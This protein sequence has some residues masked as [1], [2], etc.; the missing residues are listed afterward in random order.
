MTNRRW[1]ALATLLAPVIALAQRM[2]NEQPVRGGD[3]H[4]GRWI[5]AVV[6]I[7]AVAAVL[8]GVRAMRRRG[9]TPGGP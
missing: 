5:L 2:A 7:A 3:M 9:P 8:F 6:L 4:L 1:A